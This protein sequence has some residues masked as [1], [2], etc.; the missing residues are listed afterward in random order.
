V[1]E[2]SNIIFCLETTTI[3]RGGINA[4]NILSALT[5]EY[6]PGL[7]TFSVIITI[8]GVDIKVGHELKIEFISEN[9]EIVV[10][11]ES[12]LPIIENPESNLPE[13]YKGININM[14]WNNVN[15]KTSG[16]YNLKIYLDSKIIKQKSIY[17]KGKNE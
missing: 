5:P 7:F 8:L 17:V 15:F 6:I 3:D 10:E 2:V 16:L 12:E 9:D 14:D 11:L 1:V 13:Q 4:N